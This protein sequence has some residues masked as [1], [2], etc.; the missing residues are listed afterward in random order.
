MLI[1]KYDYVRTET[2][3][4]PRLMSN[5]ELCFRNSREFTNNTLVRHK[6]RENKHDSPGYL[7]ICKPQ[8]ETGNI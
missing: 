4:N 5:N 3:N 1:V 2:E 6:K 7:K 8:Q